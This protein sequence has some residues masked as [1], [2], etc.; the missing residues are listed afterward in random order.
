MTLL[1]PTKYEAVTVAQLMAYKKAGADIDK[2]M[3]ITGATREQVRTIEVQSLDGI[4]DLFET[5]LSVEQMLP[6]RFIKVGKLN[7]GI[8]PN[9]TR[10][11]LGEHIDLSDNCKNFYQNAAKIMSI[12][13]R[14]VVER[15]GDQYIIEPYSPERSEMYRDEL[16]KEINIAQMN[17][18]MV[19]FST[20]ANELSL[21]SPTHSTRQLLKAAKELRRASTE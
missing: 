20:I 8:I 19:F 13:Y 12:I 11:T 6:A 16:A 14:P 15:I 4:I 1:I 18:A 5:L 9:F 21:N 7:L 17:W 2:V 3:A 10:I